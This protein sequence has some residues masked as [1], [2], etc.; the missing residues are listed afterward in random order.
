MIFNF[1]NLV[2]E[3]RMD[4]R[5]I[6]HVGGYVGEESILYFRRGINNVIFFEPVPKHYNVLKRNTMYRVVNKAVGSSKGKQKIHL[7]K[8]DGGFAN[9]SGASSSLLKPKKHLEQYPHI[10][11]EDEIEVDVIT[12]TDFVIENEINLYN[13]NML[14]I[15]VQGYEL[16]VLRGADSILDSIDYIL[17]EVNRDEL[18]EGCPMIE[19]LDS[20]LLRHNFSRVATNWEG[21]TWGDALY[22]R[23]KND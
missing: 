15:D 20:Y 5:G 8:T 17:T 3:N 23:N 4:I 14:N 1:D 19:D 11:F 22:I 21:G 10:T 18:Y 2:H 6:F 16:E 7:S 13:F 9:G 12:L